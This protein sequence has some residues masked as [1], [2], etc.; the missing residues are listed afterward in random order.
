M[1]VIFFCNWHTL[2]AIVEN[3]QVSIQHQLGY[4]Q[5]DVY[6]KDM[7]ICFVRFMFDIVDEK[8]CLFLSIE[9]KFY[10]GH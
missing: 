6:V 9:T 5:R 4:Y 1:V 10:C 2:F 7:R 3:S 8:E